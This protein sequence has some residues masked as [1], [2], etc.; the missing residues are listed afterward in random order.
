MGAA[1]EPSAFMLLLC[2][3]PSSVFLA[4]LQACATTQQRVRQRLPCSC[5]PP[6]G[7]WRR[8]WAAALALPPSLWQVSSAFTIQVACLCQ[9]VI[10][11]CFAMGR[12][13]CRCA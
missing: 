3:M 10:Q 2:E 8:L 6:A 9:R 13:C 7:G 1:P 4:K 12:C 11:P 5:W